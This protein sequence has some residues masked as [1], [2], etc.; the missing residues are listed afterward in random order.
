M[1]VVFTVL[2]A[3]PVRHVGV[4]H[5]PVLHDLARSGASAPGGAL[6]VM[7]SATYPNHATFSTGAEPRQHGVATNWIPQSGGVVPAWK[8]G[9]QVPTLFD[10][11]RAAGRT[12]TAVGNHLT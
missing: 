6:G 9:P 8:R 5:T 12:S 11:C 3:L 7:T 4:E 2:D 10:A 1:R